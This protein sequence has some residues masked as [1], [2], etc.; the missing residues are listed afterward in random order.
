MVRRAWGS[1]EE[2]K[3]CSKDGVDD[4]VDDDAGAREHQKPEV[5]GLESGAEQ[6]CDEHEQ[7]DESQK[8]SEHFVFQS[9]GV[10]DCYF[11]L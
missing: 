10:D 11:I 1:G 4:D 2:Q 9:V 7:P 3:Y 8:D 6:A 5:P